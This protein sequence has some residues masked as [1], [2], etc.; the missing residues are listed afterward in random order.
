MNETRISGVLVRHHHPLSDIAVNNLRS[1]I[2]IIPVQ[3]LR[4]LSEFLC[5]RRFLDLS[6]SAAR[7]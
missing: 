1:T 2:R 3:H 5:V 4:G 7:G 6:L